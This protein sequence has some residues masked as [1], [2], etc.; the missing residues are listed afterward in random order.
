MLEVARVETCTMPHGSRFNA[1]G[2]RHYSTCM[3]DDALV[4]IDATTFKLARHFVL[5]PGSEQGG[6]GRPG[7]TGGSDHSSHG[8]TDFA[9]AAQGGMGPRR[10][11]GISQV[12]RCPARENA[13]LRVVAQI[14]SAPL[15]SFG[16]A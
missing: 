16:V 11:L 2:T 7:V 15:I 4:E 1:R 5:T 8:M 13:L 9:A 3:M 12:L 14:Q 10:A 6:T